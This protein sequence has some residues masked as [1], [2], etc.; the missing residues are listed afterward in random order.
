VAQV[1]LAPLQQLMNFHHC[2]QTAE[3]NNP[4]KLGAWH[5]TNLKL[6]ATATR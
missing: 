1:P 3:K 5:K 6:E 2:V 4:V